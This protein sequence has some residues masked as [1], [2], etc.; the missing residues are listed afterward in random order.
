MQPSTRFSL[1]TLFHN[2]FTCKTALLR[3]V[4]IVTYIVQLEQIK[5][6]VRQFNIAQHSTSYLILVINTLLTCSNYIMQQYYTE[7]VLRRGQLFKNSKMER[8]TSKQQC[9][10]QQVVSNHTNSFFSSSSEYLL[11]SSDR[12]SSIDEY[13]CYSIRT[14]GLACSEEEKQQ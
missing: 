1:Y 14:L 12:C 11:V 8:S 2:Y 10:Y 3:N 5:Q 9:S 4:H 6:I 13:K 7:G